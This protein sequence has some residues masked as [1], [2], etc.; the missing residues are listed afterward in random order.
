MISIF[1]QVTGMLMQLDL[2]MLE[3]VLT[4]ADLLSARVDIA[5]QALVNQRG[6]DAVY[7]SAEYGILTM[8]SDYSF[9]PVPQVPTVKSPIKEQDTGVNHDEKLNDDDEPLFYEPGRPGFY[10]VRPGKNSPA[11]LTAFKNVGR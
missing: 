5:M 9:Q 6:P 3:R 1:I 8:P 2:S 11:R 10:A 7:H 4:D